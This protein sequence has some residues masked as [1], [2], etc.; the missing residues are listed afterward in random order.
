MSLRELRR[1]RAKY[2]E[3]RDGTMGAASAVRFLDP[4]S[5]TIPDMK[6]TRSNP[7]RQGLQHRAE[8]EQARWLR[9]IPK[10]ERER[11]ERRI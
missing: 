5:V 9:S 8:R 1:Q 7:P 11:L 6:P 10:H 2:L 3:R 4:G